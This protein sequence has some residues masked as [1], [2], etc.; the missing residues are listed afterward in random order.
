MVHS[1]FAQ[2]HVM[3]CRDTSPLGIPKSPSFHSGLDLVAS[4]SVDSLVA[5]QT[6]AYIETETNNT[7]TFKFDEPSNCIFTRKSYYASNKNNE[8]ENGRS[9]TNS[10]TA[11]PAKNGETGKKTV[12]QLQLPLQKNENAVR[13]LQL[14]GQLTS[15]A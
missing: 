5:A 9:T 14:V 7:V 2:G 11:A 12:P 15:L 10:T 4:A 1:T 13:T 3:G 8:E 6:S